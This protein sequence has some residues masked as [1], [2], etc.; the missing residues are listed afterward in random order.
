[1]SASW[2]TIR[3]VDYGGKD[4]QDYPPPPLLLPLYASPNYNPTLL[5]IASCPV[6][7][8]AF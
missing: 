3:K 6:P 2:W 1:M 4:G 5:P 7:F 8:F